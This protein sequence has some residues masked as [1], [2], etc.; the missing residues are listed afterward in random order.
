MRRKRFNRKIREVLRLVADGLPVA[1]ACSM[2]G[3]ARSSFYDRL[4]RD[5]QL[6]QELEAAESELMCLALRNVRAAIA[7]GDLKV[8]LWYLERRLPEYAPHSALREK[9]QTEEE[10]PRDI[11]VRFIHPDAK[12]AQEPEE[13]ET[14]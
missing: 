14:A 8:S 2:V 10:K 13:E 6:Q 5:E 11:I 3:I 9:L 4:E 7:G 12:E 1:R